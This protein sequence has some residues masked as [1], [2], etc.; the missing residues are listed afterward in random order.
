M[1]PN[2]KVP[3]PHDDDRASHAPPPVP[4]ANRPERTAGTGPSYVLQ[5]GSY[6]STTEADQVRSRLARAGIPAQIQRI[7]AGSS[8]WNR[9]R[10]GPLSDAELAKVREQLRT[11]N[12][13]AMVIRADR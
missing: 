6:R 12:I 11:A 1:L 9:V 7:V 4:V 10:I 13:H 5:V 8:T 2:F 3:V